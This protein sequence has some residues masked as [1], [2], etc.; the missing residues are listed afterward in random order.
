MI[1]S[2][3]DTAADGSLHMKATGHAGAASKGQDLVCAGVSTLAQTLAEAVERLYYQGMLRRCPRVELYEGN[4]EIIAQP[5]PD[6]RAEAAMVFWTVQN[7]IAA[8]A[9]SF[10]ENVALEEVMRVR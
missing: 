1:L 8:L 10:P 6:F 7:G 2:K 4:A 9:E 5:K 3:F